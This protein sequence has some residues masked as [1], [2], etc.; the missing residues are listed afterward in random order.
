MSQRTRQVLELFMSIIAITLVLVGCGS[1]QNSANSKPA[2]VTIFQSK[3]EITDDLKNLAK[4][5]EKETGQ[6]VE[7]WVTTGDDYTTQ[8][9]TKLSNRNSSPNLFSTGGGQESAQLR[10]YMADLSDQPFVKDIVKGRALTYDGKIYGLPYSVEGYGLI[11]NTALVKPSEMTSTD[12]FIEYLKA[13]KAQGKYTGFELSSET[14]FLIAHMLNNA[15]AIQ[16]DPAAFLK[17]VESG[18]VQL[19]NVPAFKELGQIYEAIRE[20]TKNPMSVKYDDQIGD[21]MSG[22]TAMVNQG[23]WINTM[24]KDYKNSNV[25]LDMM[26]FPLTGNKKLNVSVPLYWNVNKN[27]PANEVKASEKFL[28]WLV[29]SKT[30]QDYIVNKFKFIPVYT[31]IKIDQSKMDSLS[32]AIYKAAQSG[33][34]MSASTSAWPVGA[35]DTTFAPITEK[36]FSNKSMTGQELMKEISAGFVSTAKSK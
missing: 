25:K 30:G 18:K 4:A 20:Y 29:T 28:N 22:K 12:Q 13:A 11:Y 35:I 9:K 32:L 14:Y 8:V 26:P 6:K 34:T 2:K 24:L 15:F 5:Y 19:Q 36:F 23:M 16:K 33:N 1:K 10:S 31:N 3:V 17:D 27:K 21:L 7:V